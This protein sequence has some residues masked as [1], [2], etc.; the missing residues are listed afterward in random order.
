DLYRE[1][2]ERAGIGDG[3]HG[4][5]IKL[6]EKHV[7]S[8]VCE[9][10]V[11]TKSENKELKNS[12]IKVYFVDFLK[13]DSIQ[14][15]L[16]SEIDLIISFFKNINYGLD[17]FHVVLPLDKKADIDDEIFYKINNISEKITIFFQISD[18]I[19]IPISST[20][21]KTFSN[22]K[23][24]IQILVGGD[25]KQF[26]VTLN[27]VIKWFETIFT[28]D[29]KNIPYTNYLKQYLSLYAIESY[30]NSSLIRNIV[31]NKKDLQIEVGQCINIMGLDIL[32]NED[33]DEIPNL[34]NLL[35]NYKFDM[36]T[37]IFNDI[38]KKIIT[39]MR[40]NDVEKFLE[41]LNENNF[42][43]ENIKK[44]F[45]F[46]LIPKL[47]LY[48]KNPPLDL[49]DIQNLKDSKN[50]WNIGI[51]LPYIN[52][53][54]ELKDLFYELSKKEIPGWIPTEC[55]YTTVEKISKNVE[56]FSAKELNDF[57]YSYI[58][59]IDSYND[60]DKWYSRV[61]DKYFVLSAS[62]ILKIYHFLYEWT[63]KDLVNCIIR[64]Y[65]L[66]TEF[67]Q[68][69][70]KDLVETIP[71]LGRT[72]ELFN[73]IC[74]IL[75]NGELTEGNLDEVINAL[76]HFLFYDNKDALYLMREIGYLCLM[77]GLDNYAKL[78]FEKTNKIAQGDILRYYAHPLSQPEIFLY[79][80][81]KVK[82]VIRHLIPYI[83]KS[84]MF[85]LEE[86]L[87]KA[88]L[89]Y[90]N[91]LL[92]NII[93]FMLKN[94]HETS[95]VA[96]P[97]AIEFWDKFG[98]IIL[99]EL[100]KFLENNKEL[101]PS[102][103]AT[104][105]RLKLVSNF[106]GN[107]FLNEE[108]LKK[109]DNFEWLN[110]KPDNYFHK[111]DYNPF[112]NDTIFIIYSCQ[113]NLNTR[114]KEIRD[115]YIK[116]L[117]QFKIPYLIVVGGAER[118]YIED[119]ILFL[120]VPDGYEDLP[121]KTIKLLKW[122]YE[123]TPFYYVYKIDDDSY[124]DIE[125]F[126]STLQYRKFH[127]YGKKIKRFLQLDRVWHR[128]KSK[129]ETISLT[130]DKA[131][132]NISWADGGSGYSL[133][134][135]AIYKILKTLETEYGKFLS[136]LYLYEDILIGTLL[137]INDIFCNEKEY[138]VSKQFRTSTNASPVHKWENFFYPSKINPI[139]YV[140]LDTEK[141]FKKAHEIKN[142]QKLY[143]NKIWS[144]SINVKLGENSNQLELLSD[145]SK[146]KLLD[147]EPIVIVPVRNER[148]M[149]PHFLSYYRKLGVGSFVFI[150]NL[151]DDGT[152]EYLLE[153]PDVVV[154]S[155]DTEYKASHYGIC[156]QHAILSNFCI[157]KWVLLL[158]AD[159]FLVYENC[160]EVNIKDFLNNV[161][162][163][164]F[165]GVRADLIDVYPKKLEF[166]D[167]SKNSP[168]EVAIFFDKEPLIPIIYGA[169]VYSNCE[170]AYSSNLR[171]RIST[172][173]HISDFTN[174]KY[175]IFKYYPWIRFS[176]GVHF[177]TPSENFLEGEAFLFHF[178]YHSDF[179][180]K[181]VTE[182][183]RK[184]HFENA[185][186]YIRYYIALER[187]KGDLYD[188]NISLKYESSKQFIQYMRRFYKR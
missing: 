24:K 112:F 75:E 6:P 152:R 35:I 116:D 45:I 167:L 44:R 96:Y 165:K 187:N 4:F 138:Y 58:Y 84:S 178:K 72:K 82:E 39:Q 172:D 155:V 18:R 86:M 54:S 161:E 117:K 171:H 141:N 23:S 21:W 163:M 87:G 135:F 22:E 175:P 173:A 70:N 157:G 114:I 2:L 8:Y 64:N 7:K 5:R 88:L 49:K 33:N 80:E 16:K 181:V 109:V 90:K 48:E 9:I 168:F 14:T 148:K 32:N 123:N 57:V 104:L 147:K 170:I 63:K 42:I 1:D 131:Y 52:D 76:D 99:E 149:L 120:N 160:E 102:I 65:G 188:E 50:K 146:L 179:K 93:N 78:I 128:E 68:Y 38:Y 124:I 26:S 115:T 166:L 132:S 129:S 15:D 83:P 37:F 19:I 103:E 184:Q 34:L 106:T 12:P 137:G 125:K 69:I 25:I 101:P 130:L 36:G 182:V 156:W 136:S 180:K 94:G 111:N 91:D 186:E 61:Y 126:L 151:S 89:S 31:N 56:K 66:R 67:W 40:E 122:L 105:L 144:S 85:H 53:I 176:E 154:F 60:E 62:V 51:T 139:V 108:I 98:L 127:Y 20:F 134:R 121:K 11:R 107:N 97:F 164:G 118:D 95:Y 110:L 140:H 17:L 92:V 169:G 153:Q 77:K 133:T 185:R 29:F 177:V 47:S 28:K 79:E 119:D 143:P 46:T 41:L 100:S 27:D 145:R 150:D 81:V 3:R 174:V 183:L 55:V 159:E 162:S 158:D 74:S 43:P 71:I 30:L 142:Q 113:K 13:Y 59:L 10:S 73:I